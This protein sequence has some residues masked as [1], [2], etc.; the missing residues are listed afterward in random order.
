MEFLKY[1]KNIKSLVC[2]IMSILIM[3]Y[4]LFESNDKLLYAKNDSKLRQ[5]IFLSIFI[6][7]MNLYYYK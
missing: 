1:I 5:S 4:V 7:P 2:Y 6:M 3:G